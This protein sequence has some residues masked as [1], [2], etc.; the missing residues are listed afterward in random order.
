MML[1]ELQV[2]QENRLESESL[3]A[4]KERLIKEDQFPAKTQL[5]L[6]PPVEEK[7]LQKESDSTNQIPPDEEGFLNDDLVI[8]RWRIVQPLCRTQGAKEGTFRNTLT[9]E[10]R[11]R[12]DN[13]ILLSRK[14]GRVL[15]PEGDF[16]GTRLCWSYDGLIPEIEEIVRKTEKP[17]KSNRCIIKN[18]GSTRVNCPFA[19]WNQNGKKAPQCRETI[20]FLGIDADYLPFWIIF[21][22]NGIPP[23][24]DFISTIYLKKKQANLKGKDVHFRDF[25]ILLTLQLEMQGKGKY[26]I[27]VVQKIEEITDVSKRQIITKCFESLN[28]RSICE[29]FDAETENS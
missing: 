21:G 24:K 7:E 11:E 13:V 14:N 22:G 5:R 23:V 4:T 16:T 10:E 18:N 25:Q 28:K 1:S 2:L 8:P 26:Y 12:L 3:N 17:P 20:T 6:M 9:G 15:F 29:T 19:V 27:P